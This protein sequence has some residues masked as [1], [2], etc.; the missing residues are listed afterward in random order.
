[1]SAGAALGELAIVAALVVGCASFLAAPSGGSSPARPT[2]SLSTPGGPSPWP[3]GPERLVAIR[4]SVDGER[5]VECGGLHFP[6]S[7]LEEDDVEDVPVDL[8]DSLDA[9]A[10]FWR[11]EFPGLERLT[12]RLVQRDEGSASFLARSDG[13]DG[14][15]YL[16]LERDGD[17]WTPTGVGGCRPNAVLE[18]SGA[19]HWVLNP[20]YR[21]PGHDATELHV[22]IT[23]RA[24]ASGQ[25]AFGRLSPPVV[26]YTSDALTLTVGV[27]PVGGGATCP[28][29]PPTP[30][31]I[32]LPE[33]LGARVL[34]DGG[35]EPPAPPTADY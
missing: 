7:F 27:R 33:P 35:R 18:E 15:T 24:C 8:A 29:I 17:G 34:L 16:G 4:E 3:T 19:A 26:A 22:L 1:M 28:S 25:P 13:D 23:E 10:R 6:S 12:W 31:T 9:A 5:M 11:D 32:I 14:W 30:A 20:A 21:P 2:P